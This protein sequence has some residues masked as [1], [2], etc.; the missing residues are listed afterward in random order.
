M[1]TIKKYSTYHF[2]AIVVIE[3]NFMLRSFPDVYISCKKKID[4]N[5]I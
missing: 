3:N 2:S 4:K 1:L 5:H